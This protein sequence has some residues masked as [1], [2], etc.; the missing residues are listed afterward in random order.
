MPRPRLRFLAAGLV[1]IAANAPVLA[2]GG[3]VVSVGPRGFLELPKIDEVDR[4]IAAFSRG[5]HEKALEALAAAS[6]AA[7]A[8]GPPRL[9]L[10]KL[11]MLNG[12]IPAGRAELERAA[13]EGPPHPEIHV[14]LAG[15]GAE[16]GRLS[17]ATL[18]LDRAAGLVKAGDLD[19]DARR[20]ANARIQSIRATIAERRP[21]WPSAVAALTTLV[22]LSPK[23][24]NA[25]QRLGWALFRSGRKEDAYGHLKAA[26][27]MDPSLDPPS[28]QMGDLYTEAGQIDKAGEWMEHGI[29]AAPKDARARSA[30]AA[31]L[32]NRE[33]PEEAKAQADAAVA[34]DGAS[35]VARTL[36]GLSALH[37]EHFD[38]AERIFQALHDEAPSRPLPLNYLALALADQDDPAKAR[39]ALEYAEIQARLAPESSAALATLGWVNERLGRRDVAER[40]L[41]MALT[42]PQPTPEAAYYL[43]RVLLEKGATDEAKTWLQRAAES[44]GPFAHRKDA[45]ARLQGLSR[46]KPG[47]SPE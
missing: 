41:R 23:D 2:T 24:A 44:T 3:P 14:V 1:L 46:P 36:Q 35:T 8:L 40:A 31:W 22:E 34:I 19:D 17:D 15:L 29:K 5:D 18:Q 11:L 25:R 28:A 43:G 21:D 37:L 13:A 12:Q 6:K 16:E 32:L 30:Y 10:A 27:E 4:A 39:R 38:E 45:K 47:E 9:M 42:K 20:G 7:P 26:S 33:R